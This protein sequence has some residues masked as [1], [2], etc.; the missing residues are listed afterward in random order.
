MSGN[1]TNRWSTGLS[2]MK[3]RNFISEIYN[4]EMELKGSDATIEE[5]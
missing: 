5:N 3:S 1:P 4:R 2:C